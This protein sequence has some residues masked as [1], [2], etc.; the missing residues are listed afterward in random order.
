MLLNVL[1]AGAQLLHWHDIGC[2]I[3]GLIGNAI[4]DALR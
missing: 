4:Q 3:G 1:S 2:F